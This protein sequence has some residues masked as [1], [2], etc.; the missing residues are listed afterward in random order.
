MNRFATLVLFFFSVYGVSQDTHILMQHEQAKV[1]DAVLEER[2]RTVLPG[3]MRREGIDPARA[4][5]PAWRH[6]LGFTVSGAWP[7][8]KL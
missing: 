3:L 5:R 4:S 7:C 8:K 6:R 2:L 1:M